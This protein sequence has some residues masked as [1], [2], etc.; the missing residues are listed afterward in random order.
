MVKFARQMGEASAEV[1]ET[2]EAMR[3]LLP[4]ALRPNLRGTPTNC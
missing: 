3:E 1:Q 4:A 2:T